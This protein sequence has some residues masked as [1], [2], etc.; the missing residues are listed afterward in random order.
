MLAKSQPD[1]RRR[2]RQVFDEQFSPER[3]LLELERIYQIAIDRRSRI[4]AE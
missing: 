3:N 4:A 2:A 1:V